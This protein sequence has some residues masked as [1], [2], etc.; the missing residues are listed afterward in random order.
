VAAYARKGDTENAAA[1]LN[2]MIGDYLD[3]KDDRVKPDFALFD[4]VIKA[5]SVLPNVSMSDAFRAESVLRSMWSLHDSGLHGVRPHANTYKNIVVCFKKA[6]LPH[7]SEDYLWEMESKSVGKPYKA[8]FQTVLNA[9]HGSH[10]P[11]KQSHIS[12]LRLAMTHR[13]GR[14]T[15]NVSLGNRGGS[16]NSKK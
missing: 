16:L 12:A 5:T 11:N 6:G 9:W 3:C 7:R 15:E 2:R 14:E 4:L 10:H 13:F 8:L 1:V